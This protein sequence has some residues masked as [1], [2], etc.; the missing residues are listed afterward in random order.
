ML[1]YSPILHH[2]TADHW[3]VLNAAK[4]YLLPLIDRTSSLTLTQDYLHPG[5]D[6]HLVFDSSFCKTGMLA[7][8]GIYP[9]FSSCLPSCFFSSPSSSTSTSSFWSTTPPPSYSPSCPSSILMTIHRSRLARSLPC[10]LR[11]RRRTHRHPQL[12]GSRRPH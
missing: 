12:L 1:Q 9:S 6:D 7:C 5:Q 4:R 11:T 3:N 2:A 10:P 8:W